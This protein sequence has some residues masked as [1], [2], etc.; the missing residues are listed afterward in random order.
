MLAYRSCYHAH[1]L[2]PAAES[3][4]SLQLAIWGQ[5]LNVLDQIIVRLSCKLTK[6]AFSVVCSV[7]VCMFQR[8]SMAAVA[9]G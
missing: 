9:I 2:F 5:R 7:C 8:K 3:N 6:H 4:L 1:T